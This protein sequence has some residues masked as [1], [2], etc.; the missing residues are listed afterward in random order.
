MVPVSE[1]PDE[2]TR[3][4]PR[5]DRRV[6]PRYGLGVPVLV[7]APDDP[8]G[9]RSFVRD[10]SAGGCLIETECAVAVGF[11][12]AV[13]F[14]LKPYGLCRAVGRVVRVTSTR[15]FGVQFVETN[16]GFRELLAALADV[17]AERRAELLLASM[18]SVVEITPVAPARR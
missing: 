16:Q 9:V 4:V 6:H 1:F 3:S 12:V 15:G 10:L 7:T 2:P 11:G 8:G 5:A 17:P 18:G 14:L 13:A